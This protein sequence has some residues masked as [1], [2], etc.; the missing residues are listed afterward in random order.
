M[1]NIIKLKEMINKSNNIVVFT[2]AGV[3]TD[4]GLKD[5]RSKDGIY[6]IKLDYNKSPEYMLSSECFNNET[7]LFYEFYRK[8]MIVDNVTP[9]ITHMYL[10]KLEDVGKLKALITQNI[11][12]L[13]KLAG[14][15]NVYEIHG[16]IYKNYCIKCKKEYDLNY[17][18]NSKGIPKCRCGGIIKPNVVLYGE[19]LPEEE[20]NNSIKEISKCDMLMVLGTSL[21]VYPASDLV[22]FFR[23]KYLVIINRDETSYDY[24]ADLVIH[25]SLKDVFKEVDYGE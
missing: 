4:S 11:D 12:G 17:I 22:R 7:H 25:D 13:H 19:M 23:G 10:K 20:Y 6:N 16:S 5:F 1:N 9:N 24:R 2:G 14:N 21:T 8:Y 18:K 3:S 15:N